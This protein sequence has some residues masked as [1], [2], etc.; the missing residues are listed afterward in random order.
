MANTAQDITLGFSYNPAG[1]IATHSRS[2]DAYSWSGHYNID[3]PYTVNGLNQLTS[4]GSVSLGYDGR[5]KLTTSG[6]T[7]YGYT[8]ENRMAT[9]QVPGQPGVSLA[10][11]AGGRLWMVTKALAVTRFDMLSR[12][13][14]CARQDSNLLPQD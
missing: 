7:A 10:Y 9:Q 2:N 11:D 5:G 3:R 12:T 6:T 13:V 8:A 14:W 1:Q 4:A